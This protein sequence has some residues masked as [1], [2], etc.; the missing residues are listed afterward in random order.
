MQV[1]GKSKESGRRIGNM[2][3]GGH[4]RLYD[5]LKGE[6]ESELEDIEEK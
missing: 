1:S 5:G 6:E 4:F 3:V 2:P